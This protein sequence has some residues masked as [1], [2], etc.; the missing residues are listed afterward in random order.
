MMPTGFG[1]LTI[2][3]GVALVPALLFWRVP[4]RGKKVPARVVVCLMVVFLFSLVQW[5]SWYK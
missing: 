5:A 4:Y 2:L 1:W 3:S